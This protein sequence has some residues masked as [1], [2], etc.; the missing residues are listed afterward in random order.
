MVGGDADAEP[1]EVAV[2]RILLTGASGFIG[3]RAM[4]AMVEAGHDVY[5]VSS[6]EREQLAGVRWLRGD[7]LDRDS[8]G[9]LVARARPEWLMHLAWTAEPGVYWTSPENLS[10]VEATLRLLRAFADVGGE[11]AVLAGTC[12]EYEW[13]SGS[14]ICEEESTPIRPRALYG[15]SKNATRTIAESFA[16]AS[17]FEVCWG[18]I[19]FL[20][21]PGEPA[22]RL[23]PAVARALLQK[24]SVPVSDGTQ[25][26]DF[27]HVDDVAGA[28]VALLESQVTG[29]VNIGSG[30]PITVRE[31]IEL[32]AAEAGSRELVRFG[33][34]APRPG[35]PATLLADVRR[36]RE[37][38]GFTPRIPIEQGIA[39]TVAWWREQLPA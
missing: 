7:L 8:A 1:E 36:L 20:Y 17:G 29:P 16:A 10:W 25:V 19:F 37:T 4:V 14:G 32:V 15:V 21:G 23:V 30:Q 35:D 24:Q 31:L 34:L 5:A 13:G 12:A 28:F 26:R 22:A 3:S 18:R 27:L 11:R 33:A 38:V 9:E 6:R 2:S 39:E